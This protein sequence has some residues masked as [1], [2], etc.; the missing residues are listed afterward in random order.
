M[1]ARCGPAVRDLQVRG[2]LPDRCPDLLRLT[3]ER[4]GVSASWYA[5]RIRS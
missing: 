1:A 3:S 5:S 4:R 2:P